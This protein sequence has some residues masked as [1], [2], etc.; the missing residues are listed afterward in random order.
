MKKEKEVLKEEQEEE[1]MEERGQEELLELLS[2]VSME[3]FLT[4]L[5]VFDYLVKNKGV[6]QISEKDMEKVQEM[7]QTRAVEFTTNISEDGEK[8]LMARLVF[9]RE[10]EKDEEVDNN[11]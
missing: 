2:S 3:E 7:R 6:V 9:H 4:D 11:D 8:T 10:G 1:E 5:M